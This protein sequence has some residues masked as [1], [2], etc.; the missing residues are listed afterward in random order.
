MPPA[1]AAADLPPLMSRH[2]R[3]CLAAMI[4]GR[5]HL[6]EYGAGGSTVLAVAQGVGRIDSVES[7]P[8]WI[9]RLARRTDIRAAI[10]DGRLALHHAD[11]GAVGPWG[12]PIDDTAAERWPD[13]AQRIWTQLPEGSGP[14]S[15]DA[16][17]VDGRFRASC[18]LAALT[19]VRPGTPIIVHDFWNRPGYAVVLPVLVPM[20]RVDT[21]AIFVARQPIDREQVAV[22][23]RSVAFAVT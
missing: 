4:A 21:L 7:D 23:A 10:A 5:R 9:E 2:E 16:V 6:V 20:L 3:L 8:A 14:R 13:Y 15:V 1:E 11:I 19:Q 17:L 18:I 12:F 22:L